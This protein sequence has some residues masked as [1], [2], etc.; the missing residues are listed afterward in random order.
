MLNVFLVE[1]NLLIRKNLEETL[2]ELVGATLVGTADSE[3]GATQW[4]AA[5]PQIWDLA[6]VDLF[7]K[8][9]TGLPVIVASKDRTSR[10][11]VIVLSNYLSPEVRSKCLALGADAVFDKTH[12]I[13][14]FVAFCIDLKTT[15][16]SMG[17]TPSQ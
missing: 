1:D 4:L 3:A 11:K 5:N 14:R 15:F 13:E 16:M 12:D 7:L 2:S 8:Q 10:Q 9:G 6:I 17:L